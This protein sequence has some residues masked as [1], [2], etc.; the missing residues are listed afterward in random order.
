M[1]IT[2]YGLMD[3]VFSRLCSMI[4]TYRSH[5]TDHLVMSE[6]VTE[7]NMKSTMFTL[8]Q[9]YHQKITHAYV[10]Y[11]KRSFPLIHQLGVEAVSFVGGFQT[12]GRNKVDKREIKNN[13]SNR[14]CTGTLSV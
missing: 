5:G 2:G 7:I 13:R 10:L 9:I 4:S 3:L 12:Q 6:F 8:S 1:V 14:Q 11:H